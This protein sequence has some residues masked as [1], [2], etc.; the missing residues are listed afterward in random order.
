MSW[1]SWSRA[2]IEGLIVDRGWSLWVSVIWLVAS[3]YCT[4]ND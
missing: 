4:G 1:R 2:E 3:V